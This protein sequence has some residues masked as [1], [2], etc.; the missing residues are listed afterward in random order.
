MF[1]SFSGMVVAG[2]L[3]RTGERSCYPRF[4]EC[5]SFTQHAK[6]VSRAARRIGKAQ[7]EIVPIEEYLFRHDDRCEVDRMR[8]RRYPHHRDDS[9]RYTDQGRAL[10]LQDV[11][12]PVQAVADCIRAFHTG[13]IIWPVCLF[14]VKPP[15]AC[16][17]R[18]F[19][20]GSTFEQ[21]FVTIR[22]PS[23]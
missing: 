12:L 23:L 21:I 1:D 9:A 7:V 16:G 20:F 5:G 6:F 19:G 22:F 10:V 3:T 13:H 14:P 15:V 4:K 18:S 2:R 17:R 8:R 11:S